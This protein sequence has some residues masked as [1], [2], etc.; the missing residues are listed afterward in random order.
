MLIL[1]LLSSVIEILVSTNLLKIFINASKS[2]NFNPNGNNYES[3][4]YK[5]ISASHRKVFEDIEKYPNDEYKKYQLI[6]DFIS[7]MTDT[8]AIDLFQELKGIKI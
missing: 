2:V 4:L 3:R 6:V 8:Y 1:L 5:I 7:G